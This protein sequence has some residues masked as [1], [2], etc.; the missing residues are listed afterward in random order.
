VPTEVADAVKA[1][2]ARRGL[3][4]GDVAAEILSAHFGVDYGPTRNSRDQEALELTA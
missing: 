2:A 3:P 1:E 4:Y